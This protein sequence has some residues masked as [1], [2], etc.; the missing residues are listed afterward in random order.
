VALDDS[1]G[2]GIA[3]RFIGMNDIPDPLVTP[4]VMTFVPE[5]SAIVSVLAAG[6]L[7]RR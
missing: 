4:A 5:P 3:I 7:R 1:D 6:L 2:L